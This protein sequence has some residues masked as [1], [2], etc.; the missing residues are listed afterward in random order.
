M[1]ELDCINNLF[2]LLTLQGI[3]LYN[4]AMGF[5][6]FTDK[7]N[8]AICVGDTVIDSFYEYYTVIED[9]HL[10]F[11]IQHLETKTIEKINYKF[12]SL[13]TIINGQKFKQPL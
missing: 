10:G 6:G 13:L 3:V 8:R 7:Y 5:T 2:T 9:S 11:C 1:Y 4:E 12:S